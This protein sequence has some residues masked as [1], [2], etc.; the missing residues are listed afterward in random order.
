M[1]TLP[2]LPLTDQILLPGMVVPVTLDAETQ[3]A[4]DAARTGGENKLLAVPRLDGAYGPVGTVATIE[5]VGRLASGEPAA[6]LRGTARARIGSG[7]PGAGA[8]LWVEATVLDEE[9]PT[10][11]ARELAREYKALVRSVLQKRG[12]WQ[13]IDAVERMTDLAELA[14]SAGY[15]PWLTLEQKAELLAT[16]GLTERLE[17]L[18]AWIKEHVTEQEVSDKITEDVREGL[19]KG[20]REFLLRQQLAAI[21]K[22]LGEDEPDG[23]GD[24]R[25][26]VEEATLPDNVREAAMREVGRLERASDQSP[27]SGWIRTWLD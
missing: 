1:T 5:Q 15:A 25:T 8:A 3:A 14:D 7:V 23:A 4:V 18:V 9:A 6:V 19:E 16:T 13:V 12:A 17:H 22:E 11:K 10:G 26:R 20:Q 21:R 24:Y 27:E 2:V